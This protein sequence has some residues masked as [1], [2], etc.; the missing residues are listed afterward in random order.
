MPGKNTAVF[1]IYPDR[2]AAEEAV[3]S[4]RAA[5]FRSTDVS[6]LLPENSGTKDLAHEKHTKAPEGAAT[7]GFAG[8]I[9]G[10]V[11]GWLTGIGALTIPGLGPL[12]AA[13]PIVAALAGAGAVG[14]LGGIMGGL[15]GMGVPEYEARRYEG[16]IREGGVLLSVHCDSREW[17]KKAK[18][19][20]ADTGAQDVAP[21]SEKPGDFANADKPMPRM[22]RA[23]GTD[24]P[25]PS[26]EL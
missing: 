14:A 3:S 5:G 15:A 18:Q 13:G 2:V 7:G 16:R 12:I 20:L 24:A 10:G 22:R 8:G 9:A 17:V 25:L 21:S 4:L 26:D 19:I 1:G 6:V 23:G 11:L